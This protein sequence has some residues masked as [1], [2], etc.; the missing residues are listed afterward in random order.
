MVFKKRIRPKHWTTN[1]RVCPKMP[2]PVHR[3]VSLEC[4]NFFCAF[5]DSK[6]LA[7]SKILFIVTS[8]FFVENKSETV[9]YLWQ[10]WIFFLKRRVHISLRRAH[11]I[12]KFFFSL[13][14]VVYTLSKCF[15][16]A[17]LEYTWR[18][19]HINCPA[20]TRNSCFKTTNVFFLPIW[21]KIH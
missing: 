20:A 16:H 10:A 6:S 8:P 17:R 2:A 13:E 14:Y 3:K 18:N 12:K 1:I 7:F 19:T 11:K 15:V 9:P 21:I 4:V 5:P